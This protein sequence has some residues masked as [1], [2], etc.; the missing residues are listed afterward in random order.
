MIAEL[1]ARK[2]ATDAASFAAI[3]ARNKFG[4]A[5]AA[6][7]STSG[8]N[9]ISAYPRISPAFARPSPVNLPALFRI[10][11]SDKCPSTIAA[12]AENGMKIRIAMIKLAIALPLV[13]AGP[14][15]AYVEPGI[16]TATGAAPLGAAVLATYPGTPTG[17]VPAGPA[18]LIELVATLFPHLGQKI[19]AS[20]IISPQ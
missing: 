5:I 17:T 14:T 4:I 19:V 16:P 13:S 1:Y 10:S 20:A 2:L 12:T 11:D 7:I 8:I 18:L 15:G 9:A 3:F 6:I